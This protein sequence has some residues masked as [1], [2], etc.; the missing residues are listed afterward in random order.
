M[1]W[2]LADVESHNK[3]LSDQAKAQWV[4]VANSMLKRCMADGGSEST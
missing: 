3:G 1:P 2:T 4:A